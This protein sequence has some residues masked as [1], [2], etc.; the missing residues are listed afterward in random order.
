MGTDVPDDSVGPRAAREIRGTPSP[1]ASRN[2]RNYRGGRPSTSQPCRV[3]GV[4]QRVVHTDWLQARVNID[5][6]VE[7]DRHSYSMLDR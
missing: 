4:P 1:G 3:D 7:I 6:H 5:Y 2:S